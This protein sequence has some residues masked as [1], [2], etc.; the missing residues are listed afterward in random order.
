MRVAIGC[1]RHQHAAVSSST[2]STTST[3]MSR[4]RIVRKLKE[5]RSSTAAGHPRFGPAPRVRRCARR[6][7][8]DW[9]RGAAAHRVLADEELKSIAAQG[10]DALNV[11]ADDTGSH[12]PLS[13]RK[14]R[15]ARTS[16]RSSASSVQGHAPEVRAAETTRSASSPDGTSSSA[17]A[18]PQRRRWRSTCS[19]RA[20]AAK[21]P[22]PASVRDGQGGRTS[23]GR[24]RC[25]RSDRPRTEFTYDELR[26]S[27]RNVSRGAAAAAR[28]D[29]RARADE[30]DGEEKSKVSRSSIRRG[31]RA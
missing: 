30:Q 7:G 23:T 21:R 13:R 10:F 5:L 9:S 8:D 31:T 4:L 24:P 14:F 19:R 3:R 17:P 11:R 18:R 27:L 25:D 16:C 22:D 28:G 6:E 26:A 2:T 20:P 29:A 1:S 15:R 12:P